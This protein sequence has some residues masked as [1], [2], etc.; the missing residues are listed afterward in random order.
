MTTTMGYADGIPYFRVKSLLGFHYVIYIV[1]SHIPKSQPLIKFSYRTLLRAGIL[2]C[3]IS[4]IL[5]CNLHSK[6]DE[7]PTWDSDEITM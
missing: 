2:G 5:L 7:I 6:I 4:S 3:G 1:K